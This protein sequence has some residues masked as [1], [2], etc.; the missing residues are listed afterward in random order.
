MFHAIEFILLYEGSD[1]CLPAC[2]TKSDPPNTKCTIIYKL[3]TRVAVHTKRCETLANF[4]ELPLEDPN[5]RRHNEIA[6]YRH[7]RKNYCGIPNCGYSHDPGIIAAAR[8]QQIIDLTNAKR[9]MQA[10]HQAVMKTF[11]KQGAKVF[12]GEFLQRSVFLKIPTQPP[13]ISSRTVS[14]H[15]SLL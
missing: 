5:S 2:D 10:G 4:S 11:E 6:C 15:I 12:N 13:H 7:V 14:P 1:T 8:D 3:F 9:D